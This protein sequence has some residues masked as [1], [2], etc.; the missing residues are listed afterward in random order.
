MSGRMRRRASAARA[1]SLRQVAQRPLSDNAQPARQH[2]R[3]F[4]RHNDWGGDRGHHRSRVRGEPL[5][6]R[7]HTWARRRYAIRLSHGRPPARDFTDQRVASM[8]ERAMRALHT[9]C[10]DGPAVAQELLTKHPHQSD[11][12]MHRRR[13]SVSATPRTH[14]SV[15][16]QRK[17][18]VRN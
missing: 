5:A 15:I 18:R 16:C 9:R 1:K 6:R 4:L 11:T 12:A 13:R 17:Q 3:T 8:F 10:T 2:P 14:E 7:H